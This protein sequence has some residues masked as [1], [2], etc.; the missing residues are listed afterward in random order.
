[1][2]K[3]VTNNPKIVFEWRKPLGYRIRPYAY[4]W[5]LDFYWFSFRV[6]KWLCSDDDRAFHSHPTNMFIFIVKGSYRDIFMVNDK[7]IG[8]KIY[9]PG[10]IRIIKRDFKHLVKI[11]NAPC[12][13]LLFT[14]GAPKRWAFWDRITL[15]RKNRDKYFIENGHHVCD[16]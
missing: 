11:E 6:H 12:W 10:M 15:K 2:S 1:M 9:K 16:Q 4:R 5:R 3:N 14:W 13:T 7:L 8:I